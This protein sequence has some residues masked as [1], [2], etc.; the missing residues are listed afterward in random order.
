MVSY[1]DNCFSESDNGLQRTH[2]NILKEPF[3]I[4]SINDFVS[5]VDSFLLLSLFNFGIL[6]TFF[7]LKF[8]FFSLEFVLKDL[9]LEFIFFAL[10]VLK[11]VIIGRFTFFIFFD[12]IFEFLI[13]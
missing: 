2:T 13:I 1:D 3:F 10:L 12:F 4:S 11:F 8:K 7:M 9:P 6:F 5:S